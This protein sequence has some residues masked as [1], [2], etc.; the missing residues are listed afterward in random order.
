M[1]APTRPRSLAAAFGALSLVLGMVGGS[2][3]ALAQ[4]A[5]QPH[6]P[7][8]APARKLEV[9]VGLSSSAAAWFSESRFRRLLEIELQG[10]A[11]VSGAQP[12]PLADPIGWAWI[13]LPSKS[14]VSIEARINSQPPLRRVISIEGMGSDAAA[15]MVAIAGAEL[16]RALSRPSRARKA[17]PSRSACCEQVDALA[18]AMPAWVWS[19]GVGSV[20]LPGPGWLLT[21]PSASAG[22]R[23]R[24]TDLRL[25]AAWK[26]AVTQPG[27]VSWAELGLGVE[28][29]FA[30]HPRWRWSLGGVAA[31]S[32]LRLGGERSWGDDVNDRSTWS[33]RAAL[34][35]GFETRLSESTWIGLGLEPGAILR[36]ARWQQEGGS[37]TAQGAWL[38]LDL[39]LSWERRSP[40]P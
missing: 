15:R 39:A 8:S 23:Y 27:P 37:D 30:L 2:G 3:Q 1:R 12:G 5:P 10:T 33:A 20:W 32:L 28:H 40:P 19:G 21:G 25:S 26:G 38:G 14:I 29:R 7:E 24:G 6:H 35:L 13:D 9:R 31:A 17:P 16:V 4:P 11:A 18:R 34:R 22:L 36:H